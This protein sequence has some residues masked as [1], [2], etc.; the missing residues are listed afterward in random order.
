MR[1]ERLMKV[2]NVCI[3]RKKGVDVGERVRKKE[4]G[5]VK[6]MVERTREL[7]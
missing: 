3:T 6:A 5:K 2:G 1:E 7:R 4:L